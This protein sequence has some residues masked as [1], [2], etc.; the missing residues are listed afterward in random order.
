MKSTA[1]WGWLTAGVIAL[2]LNGI[3]HDGGAA[4]ANRIA[5]QTIARISNRTQ[6]VLALA[7]GR[8][9][10]F[11]ARSELVRARGETTSCRLT[12]TIAQVQ[13]KIARADTRFAGF[14]AMSAREEAQMARWEANRAQIEARLAR[15]RLAPAAFNAAEI[16]ATCLRVRVNVPRPPA[17]R[18]SV[19][20]VH[21][22]I[23]GSESF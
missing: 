6:G 14:E 22:E 15:L 17:V 9:D 7:T 3:Y 20:S 16:P 4:W 1:A 19:P 10:W 8:A 23:A 13:T 5:G 2:G 12:T 18:I 21:V 11:L